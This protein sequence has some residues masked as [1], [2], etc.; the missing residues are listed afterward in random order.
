MREVL[1][2]AAVVYRHE[3]ESLLIVAA[4]A[5]LLGPLCV[6]IASSGLR[7]AIASVPVLM[8]VYVFSYAASLRA[9]RLVL[10]SDEPDPARVF[11]ETVARLPSIVVAFAPIG[12]ALGVATACAFYVA[13]EGLSLVAF[14]L[15]LLGGVVTLAWAA[16]HTYDLPLVVGYGVGGF[17]ALRSGLQVL[18]VAPGWTARI[19]VATGLP[20]IVAFLVCWGLWFL[21]APAFGAVV[22]AAIA[23]AWLPFAALSFTG[24][25][26][27]LVSDEAVVE[28][29]AQA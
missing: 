9:A 18:E 21:I 13:N 7:A 19:F 17:D 14:A 2:E 15:G 10:D 3:A 6:L 11:F 5:V 4:P 23:A 12:L 8:I 25:C 22:F 24:A 26:I 29:P 20:L 16:R 28:E 1:E 27:R